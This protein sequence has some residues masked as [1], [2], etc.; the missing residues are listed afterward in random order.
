[1]RD[2]GATGRGGSPVAGL[3]G[4]SVSNLRLPGAW[5]P[6]ERPESRPGR[7]AAPLEIMLDAPLGAAAFNNEFGRPGLLGY[8]RTFEERVGDVERG[9]HKPIMVAGGLGHVWARHVEKLPLPSGA[10]VIQLGGPSLLIGLGGGAASSQDAGSSQ[11]ALD[12]ASVQRDNPEMQRRCQEVINRCV[13]RGAANPILSI[14]DVG[15]GGLSNAVPELLN[16]GGVGGRI[17]LARVPVADSAMSPMEIWCNES[18]ERYMLALDPAAQAWFTALCQRERCP[19]AVLGVTTRERRLQ[20]VDSRDGSLPVDLELGFLLGGAPRMERQVRRE[21]L[22]PPPL[23]LPPMDPAAALKRVLALPTV[24][25]KTFLVTI[26]DRTVTG[27]VHRDQMVGPWQVPVADVAVTLRD[28]Q[29]FSGDAMALGERAPVAL[30]D[31]PASAGL[32]LGEALTNLAA[33]DVEDLT[34][35]KL[36]ANWMAPA[37]HPGEDGVLFDMVRALGMELAPALGVAVPVGKDSLSMKTVW[38]D[39]G[40]EKSVVAPVSLVIP[41]FAPVEDVRRTLTPQLLLLSGEPTDLV[42]VDLSAGRAR[43]G[44]SALAQV[45]GQVGNQPPRL[46]RP[47]RL[48]QFFR[49]MTTLKREGLVLAYHDRSDGGLVVTLLEMAFAGGVG[50]NVDLAPLGAVA[51]LAV[52]FNEELGAVL[53]VRRSDRQRVLSRLEGCGQVHVIGEPAGDG[54]IRIRHGADSWLEQDRWTLRRQWSETSWRMQTLRDNPATALQE[55][56]AACDPHDPGRSAAL[57][58]DPRNNPAQTLQAAGGRRPRVAIL[59]EQGVN[60]HVEMAA[61]FHHAGFDAVDLHMSDLADGSRTLEEFRGLVACGGFSFGDVLGAGG[62]WAKSILQ[63][64]R[65]RE[66]F[67][68]F[69]LRADTFTLGV[70]NGCQ[71]LSHLKD[72][73]P[74]A[75]HWPRFV[76]NRSE[77]FEARLSLVEV[78]AGPSLFFRDME[79]SRLPIA[80]AH[81][82]GRAEF[83][84][85]QGL[86]HL[87]SSGLVALRFVDHHGLPTDQYPAN[88]NGSPAG[89]TG[90]T[91]A[92]GR[93]TLLM[94]HPERMFRTVQHSWHPPEWG[95]EGPWMRMFQNARA[96]V[97][98]V[99]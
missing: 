4:F 34:R 39:D 49:A 62:G 59:R 73:I 40:V 7:I 29:G 90:V 66:M 50:L 65:L 47:A 41:A 75:A 36:S 2:E 85:A 42:L 88:P 5:Q 45:F 91:S 22:L 54:V 68:R 10:L 33:A 60:G 98:S 43:L 16:D 95:E 31:G 89:V 64:P 6:W 69:F 21:R 96:W 30:I 77:Q 61:A 37:G 23:D 84:S 92:D 15:A 24:A 13:Y 81:G 67:L 80:V 18:Q 76:R 17:D 99:D 52:L 86:A 71:M 9:Y 1:M 72:L 14:H 27:L 53:Q 79:G 32:A 38:R 63:Q 78:T 11:E 25:D 44:G 51:P 97:G 46:D 70:C 35:V 55:Y 58:F 12:F 48:R 94:P 19:M 82:E 26:G 57:T 8:F 20:V 56:E 87:E 74:G 83:A 28:Y 93:A 3:V